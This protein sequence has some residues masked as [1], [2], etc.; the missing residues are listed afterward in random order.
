MA[1]LTDLF[2]YPLDIPRRPPGRPRHVP[3]PELRAT[4]RALRAE[5]ASQPT[6]CAALGLTEPTLRLHYHEELGSR[7]QA[8]R[9]HVINDGGQDGK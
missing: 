6:I 1:G 7:S 9:R 2:G 3:T 4:V 8:W 5:G